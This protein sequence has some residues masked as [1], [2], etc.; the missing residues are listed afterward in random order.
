M[1]TRQTDRHAPHMVPRS[2]STLLSPMYSA[3]F[4]RILPN[5]RSLPTLLPPRSTHNPPLP[6]PSLAHLLSASVPC[7]WRFCCYRG[8]GFTVYP[9]SVC[10]CVNVSVCMCKI[11]CVYKALVKRTELILQ[12]LQRP[13]RCDVV[14]ISADLYNQRTNHLNPPNQIFPLTNSVPPFLT[15]SF[16]P[17][18]PVSRIPLSSPVL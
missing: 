14:C 15:R 7:R 3:C 12:L 17:N 5:A 9:H 1:L 6:D 18:L 8:S 10:A 4:N 2:L 16:P 11:A 13:H